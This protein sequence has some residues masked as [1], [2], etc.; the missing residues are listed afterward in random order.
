MS[1]TTR[2]LELLDT[3]GRGAKILKMDWA[4]AYK[5]IHVRAADIPIKYF[6]WL[7]KDFVELMLVFGARSSAGIYDRLAKFV[8]CLVLAYSW[9]PANMV[10]QYLDDICSACAAGSRS[11]A[12]FETTYKAIAKD[13]GMQL[14]STADPEKAFSPCTAGITTQ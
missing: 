10:C 1:S 4:E 3:A 14:A 8:L 6:S 9:F 12:R 13:L 5:L 7:G 11:L 2:W